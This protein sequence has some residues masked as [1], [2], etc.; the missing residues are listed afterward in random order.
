MPRFVDSLLEVFPRGSSGRRL[1]MAVAMLA[2]LSGVGT[3]G[4][5]VIEGMTWFDALYMTAITLSTVGF[6]E[7]EP[8]GQTGRV[9][10]M[11]LLVTGMGTV[12]YVVGTLSEFLFE[13]RLLEVLGKRSMQK[14]I[15]SMRGH[16]V[17]CGYGRFGKTVFDRLRDNR[18]PT[19]I[20]ESDPM[21]QEQLREAGLPCIWGSALDEEVLVKA[22]VARAKAI[23]ITTPADSDNV[24]IT[25]V[26][27]ELNPS[28]KIH[29]RVETDAGARRLKLAGAN[30]IVAPYELGGERIANRILR[31]TVVDFIELAA[32]GGGAGILLE[33]VE[34]EPGCALHGTML[35]NLPT[36]SVRVAVVAIQR[37]EGPMQLMPTADA[38]LCGGDR[39]V[40]AGEREQLRRLSEVAAAK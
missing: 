6:Q 30:Q 35:R 4:Y 1:V 40:V 5:V 14:S 39:I 13:G 9:F 29:S 7:V 18:I 19:V 38:V 11:L 20:V 21:N 34:L 3:L 25:L 27:R 10:T 33:E 37:Q 2:V 32:S 17:L 8:M 36:H 31:P 12:L 24:F 22:G 16:V 26:A 28:L 23:V 15:E